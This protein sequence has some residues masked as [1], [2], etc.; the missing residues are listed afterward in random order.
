MT[1]CAQEGKKVNKD[2]LTVAVICDALGRKKT[3]PIVIG[4]HKRPHCYGRWDDKSI[5]DYYY[6]STAWMTMDIFDSWLQKFNKQMKLQNQKVLLL[7]DKTLLLL[8]WE[9]KINW[10]IILIG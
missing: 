9:E 1:S 8:S 2:R 6:N 7:I 3:R 5:V 4:K 10:L